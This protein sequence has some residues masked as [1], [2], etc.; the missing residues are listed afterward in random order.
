MER[1]HFNTMSWQ[2]LWNST[3]YTQFINA[4]LFLAIPIIG[5]L[6]GLAE[7]KIRLNAFFLI[8]IMLITW[9]MGRRSG[10][11]ATSAALAIL[12]IV[13]MINK[14]LGSTTLFFAIDAI[15][16]FI[17]FFIIVAVLSNLRNSYLTQKDIAI[18]DPLTRLYNRLGLKEILI[19]EMENAR[20]GH[21]PFALLFLDCDNFKGVNDQWGHEVGDKL[22]QVV[23][24]TILGSIRRS[25]LAS[26][27]G[28]D[29]FVIFAAY[30]NERDVEILAQKLKSNLDEV[31]RAQNWPVTLSAGAAVFEAIPRTVDTAIAFADSLMYQAKRSGKNSLRIAKWHRDGSDDDSIYCRDKTT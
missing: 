16:R 31:M 19:I 1:M 4:L 27:L 8:P 10:Y 26:R 11:L 14:P 13:S 15:G 21:H 18:R 25:D 5:L 6:D 7:G 23:A 28:G 9:R 30:T 20:R 12:L 2:S 29:E 3:Q 22:L 17:S 24:Q